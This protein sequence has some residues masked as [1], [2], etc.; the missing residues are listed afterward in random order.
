[1]SSLKDEEMKRREKLESILK[2]IV[3]SHP[4]TA[5][6]RSITYD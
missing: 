5:H 2:S 4:R 6:M 3:K 1:M